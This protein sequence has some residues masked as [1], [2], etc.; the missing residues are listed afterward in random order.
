M[1]VKVIKGKE[2]YYTSIRNKS[3]K[4]RT[5]YLGKNKEEAE[6]KEKSILEMDVP[7]DNCEPGE[8]RDIEEKTSLPLVGWIALFCSLAIGTLAGYE[9]YSTADYGNSM[10]GAVIAPS[11]I[12]LDGTSFIIGG[13]SLMVL[14]LL[15]STSYGILDKSLSEEEID[16][17]MKRFGDKIKEIDEKY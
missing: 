9:I 6:V 8:I 10:T 14:G 3:G 2:C 11:I 16:T 17:S 7:S 1:H 12:A 15:M 4:I 5:I 13:T